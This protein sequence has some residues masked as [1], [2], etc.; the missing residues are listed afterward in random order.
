MLAKLGSYEVY[1]SPFCAVYLYEARYQAPFAKTSSP[2]IYEAR[3][4]FPFHPPLQETSRLE[5]HGICVV[6]SQT[7]PSDHAYVLCRCLDTNPTSKTTACVCG[8]S[9]SLVLR[10]KAWARGI[11]PKRL[12]IECPPLAER[13]KRGQVAWGHCHCDALIG[14]Q[15]QSYRLR[16]KA[17]TYVSSSNLLSS[18]PRLPPSPP[19]SFQFCETF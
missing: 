16:L 7:R 14:S 10:A 9:C 5:S 8:V 3:V 4:G 13:V 1:V 11:H 17:K 19:P 6:D 18:F 2:Y 12:R 15:T